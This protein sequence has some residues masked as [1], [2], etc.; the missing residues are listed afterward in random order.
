MKVLLVI[1][2]LGLSTHA[3]DRTFSDYSQVFEKEMSNIDAAYHASLKAALDSYGQNLAAAKNR[4][5]S[6]GDLEGITATIQEVKRVEDENTV[7][8]KPPDGFPSLLTSVQEHY[9]EALL[10]AE[11]VRISHIIQLIKRYLAALE[12]LQKQ[13]VQQEQLD[14][15]RKVAGEIK[16]VTFVMADVESRAPLPAA[17][18]TKMKNSAQM[19]IPPN[20]KKGMVLHYRFDKAEKESV[21]DDCRNSPGVLKGAPLWLATGRVGGCYNF[22]GKGAYVLIPDNDTLHFGNDLTI[23]AWIKPNVLAS[24]PAIFSTRIISSKG[25]FQL[26][27]NAGRVGVTTDSHYDLKAQH[28][29]ETAGEWS[30]V[31]YVKSGV[32]RGGQ[33]TYL[34]GVLQTLATDSPTTF[35]DNSSPKLV[36]AGWKQESKHYFNGLLDEVM[37]WNRPLSAIEVRQ[38]HRMQK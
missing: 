35:Q 19:T 10:T 5:K 18:P 7:P 17:E 12:E 1:L 25:S 33:A 32:R 11:R 34:N 4:F 8:Q 20:L 29:M 21:T 9:H 6:K 15:A 2:L 24:R 3:A 28:G 27:L 16:R 26:E 37:V 36:G 31:V 23:S 30:H 14:E 38:L 22:H 13:L